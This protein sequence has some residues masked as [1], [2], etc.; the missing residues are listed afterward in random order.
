MATKKLNALNKTLAALT[1]SLGAINEGAALL[2]VDIGLLDPYPFQARTI[3]DQEAL[4]ELADEIKVIGIH[5]PLIVRPL[6]NGRYQII[7]GERRFRAAK[8]A[9]LSQVPVLSKP[10][11]DDEA[12]KLHL[13]ENIKRENLSQLELATRVLADYEKAGKQL[14]PLVEK[15]SMPKPKLSK[16]LAIA[17]GGDLM[18]GLIKDGVTSN[19]SVLGD[20]SRLER[21]DQKAAKVLVEKIRAEPK[22]ALAVAENFKKD[23]KPK[24]APAPVS[25]EK[26]DGAEPAWR[27][28]GLHNLGAANLRIEVRMSPHSSFQSEFVQ[29]VAKYGEARLSTR[30]RHPNSN[31]VVVNFGERNGLTRVYPAADLGLIGVYDSKDK[32]G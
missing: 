12:D 29:A 30:H 22:K 6:D 17:Q 14:A 15:Y 7:A 16:L 5:T 13:S 24:P 8:L 19:E 20:V 23:T 4:Q 25:R 21:K 28:A 26:R 11:T 32:H 1:E 9:K 10:R 18:V 31:Y 27:I 3:F 2:N